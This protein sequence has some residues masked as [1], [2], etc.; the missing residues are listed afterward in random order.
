MGSIKPRPKAPPPTIIQQ[1]APPP[2]PAAPAPTPD[3]AP[4]EPT[5]QEVLEKRE[6]SLLRRS[7]GRLGTVRTGFRGLISRA[8]ESENRPRKIL[9]GE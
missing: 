9:L 7:R 5:P 3:P 4:A 1:V 6:S 8:H 2:P